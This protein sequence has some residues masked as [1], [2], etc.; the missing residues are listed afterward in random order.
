MNTLAAILTGISVAIVAASAPTHD[1]VDLQTAPATGL[2]VAAQHAAI[3]SGVEEAAP[4]T[5]TA[6]V[7]GA[8]KAN[9][10]LVLNAMTG[11]AVAR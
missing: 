5:G 9:G 10:R 4:M 8:T 3:Q 11:S 1:D 6:K 2:A 7:D